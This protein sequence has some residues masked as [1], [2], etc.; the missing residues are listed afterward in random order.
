MISPSEYNRKKKLLLQEL[1]LAVKTGKP[2]A[3]RKKTTNLFR[4]REQGEVARIDVTDFTHVISID[5]KNRTAEVEGM[6]TYE[7]IVE[8][9]LKHG[10]MPAVVPQLKTITLGGAVTGVGIESSSFRYGFPHE[11][12]L[13]MEILT[14]DGRIVEAKPTGANKDLFFGF[15]NSYGS[16]GYA[17]KL[18]IQLVPVKKYV[19]LSHTKYSDIKKYLADM[20]NICTSKKWLDKTIDFVDGMMYRKG[21]YYIVTAQ[22]VDDAPYVSDYTYKNIYYKSMLERTEDYLTIEDYIWRWD[23]DWFW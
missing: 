10:L 20:Q 5:A 9:T 6:A 8:E 7:T 2:I 3:L 23:T 4:A 1:K 12:L 17:I 11:T 16:L 21:E 19:K 18:K 14:G 15:P 22:M 13:S